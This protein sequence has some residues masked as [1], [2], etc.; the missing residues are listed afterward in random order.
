MPGRELEKREVEKMNDCVAE[1]QLIRDD[2]PWR[3]LPGTGSDSK[4]ILLKSDLGEL[5]KIPGLRVY[6]GEFG[7]AGPVM[8]LDREAGRLVVDSGVFREIHKVDVTVLNAREP[9]A[10]LTEENPKNLESRKMAFFLL[11]SEIIATYAHIE[12]RLCLKKEIDGEDLYRADFKGTHIYFTN[13]RNEAPLSF[14]ILIYK[15]S[16]VIEIQPAE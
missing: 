3:L 7:A 9:V 10:V 16:G 1:L 15:G 14:S 11:E 12:S 2:S 5:D 4:E 8:A 13:E 6:D